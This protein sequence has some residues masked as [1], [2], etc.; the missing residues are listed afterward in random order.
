MPRFVEAYALGF[1]R[2]EL[3][4][5][6]GLIVIIG[7]CVLIL[8]R[9]RLF[10]PFLVAGAWIIAS[11]LGY[12]ERRQIYFAALL[13]PI[14][15]AAAFL[16]YRLG[17]TRAGVA[18]AIALAFIA[19]FGTMA[20]DTTAEAVRHRAEQVDRV[21]VKADGALFVRQDVP[22]LARF[23]ALLV[24]NLRPDETFYA[25]TNLATL[26]F[27]FRRPMPVRQLEVPMVESEDAQREVIARL[28]RDRQ[29]A[30]VVEHYPY[31][32]D[33]I[34]GV[35]NDQRAPLIHAWIVSEFPVRI[36]E[37]GIVLRL[38]AH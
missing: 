29:V 4:E 20:I 10:D 25:F 32:S 8:S 16:I 14:F 5:I 27:L 13:M 26:H 12:S 33:T 37:N 6:G 35:P 24:K 18:L 11:I 2:L 9:R 38:R 19:N 17:R 15:I 28:Q 31:W 22:N 1:P 7:T 36:E 21:Y 23:G 30:M 3:P 34:D